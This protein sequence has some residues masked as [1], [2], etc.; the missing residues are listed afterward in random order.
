MS[1]CVP[2]QGCHGLAMVLPELG[3]WFASWAR[4]LVKK[5]VVSAA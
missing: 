1:W 5:Y 3:G 4:E 2:E